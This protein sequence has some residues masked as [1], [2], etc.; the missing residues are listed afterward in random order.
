[1]FDSC[2]KRSCRPRV[3]WK[4][5]TSWQTMNTIHHESDHINCQIW[6][7]IQ[8]SGWEKECLE[9]PQSN[10]AHGHWNGHTLGLGQVLPFCSSGFTA[11]NGR[12]T[13]TCLHW[14]VLSNGL[15]TIRGNLIHVIHPRCIDH[16]IMSHPS[17]KLMSMLLAK[18]TYLYLSGNP[19]QFLNLSC[20]GQVV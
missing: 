5:V 10:I 3:G 12:L 4:S 7:M 15:L 18:W 14:H 20:N 13:T 16:H 6:Y 9:F 11:K 8:Y 19:L 17:V 1:M 2:L